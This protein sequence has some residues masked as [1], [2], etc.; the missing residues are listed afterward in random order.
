M[1]TPETILQFW[2]G[3]H[4]DDAQIAAAQ[5]KLWWAKDLAVDHEMRRRFAN[6]V[7]RAA[8]DGL[9]DW[10]TT[11]RGRLALILLADQ[12]PRNIYRGTA[13]AFAS[14]A[15]ALAWALDGIVLGCHR[16]LRPIERTFFYL[17][18]EHSESLEH[19]E[20][21]V[22]LFR[23][24]AHGVDASQREPFM[25][26][27][28]FAERHRDV[29]KRFGRFPHRNDILGRESTPEEQSFLKEPGSSF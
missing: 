3:A 23:T 15:K 7:R 10:Q 27:L 25:E 29:I 17:P 26:Y 2:F 14:D 21:C 1:E 13:E 16:E 18:L 22:E 9:A 5:A 6:D 11:P 24:L 28:S 19:Q 12:F 4:T 20:R 8:D